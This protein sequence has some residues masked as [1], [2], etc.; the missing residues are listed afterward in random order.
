MICVQYVRFTSSLRPVG[1]QLKSLKNQGAS[2]TSSWL[3]FFSR[4]RAR[5]C[6]NHYFNWTYWTY[7]T[8]KWKSWA[9]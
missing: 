6:V 1:V 7:W 4:A 9:F 2:S 5:P 3:Y 8:W